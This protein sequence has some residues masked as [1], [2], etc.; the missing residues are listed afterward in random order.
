MYDVNLTYISGERG[1]REDILKRRLMCSKQTLR[2]WRLTM[3]YAINVLETDYYVNKLYGVL[4]QH[5]K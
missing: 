5:G 4:V 3:N 1:G 2:M